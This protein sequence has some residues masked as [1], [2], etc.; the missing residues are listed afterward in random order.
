MSYSVCLFAP[1]V[2]RRVTAG[3]QLDL[4]E[5]PPLPAA[6][7][8]ALG[9]RLEKYGYTRDAAGPPR[10]ATYLKKVQGA[11]VEVGVYRTQISFSTSGGHEAM[12]EALQTASELCDTEA[13]AL[14]DPQQCQWGP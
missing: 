10:V 13:F 9:A 6:E 14:F 8:E 4:F 12:F 7:V 3:E 1:E 11:V 5:H 2:R